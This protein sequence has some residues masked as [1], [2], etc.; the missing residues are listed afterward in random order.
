MLEIIK[1][2]VK[3]I[4]IITSYRKCLSIQHTIN[5]VNIQLKA[6]THNLTNPIY[7]LLENLIC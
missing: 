5:L 2:D 7:E 3:I 4:I 6:K 1:I